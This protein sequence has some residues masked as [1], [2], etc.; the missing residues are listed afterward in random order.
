MQILV[1]IDDTDNLE[2]IGTGH[3]AEDL[4][5]A[6]QDKGWG[7]SQP[8][9]R[10]QLLVHEDIPY[11][12]HN[13]SMCFEA[14]VADDKVDTVIAYAQHFL[15]Q[16]HAPGSDPGL[17]VARIRDLPDPQALINF[18]RQAK[19]VVLTKTRAYDMAK[20]LNIHL[21]EHGGSGLGVIGAMAGAGLRLSGNDGRFKG[22]LHIPST[23]GVVNVAEICRRTFVQ[24]VQSLE[25]QMLAAHESIRLG[26]KVKAVL[27]KGRAVLLVYQNDN[28][29]NST[30]ETCHRQQLRI[31]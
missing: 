10:H 14:A 19:K 11:T 13:S 6:L 16:Q 1:S 9:T 29:S 8:V 23:E 5:T 7:R 26:A 18:G 4:A 20:R 21:S 17:C 22:H 3:L 27:L 12:S 28:G 25:G 15:V 24:Q 2:S 30:W 31:Y